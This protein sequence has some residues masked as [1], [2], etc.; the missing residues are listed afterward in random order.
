M[1]AVAIKWRVR[2]IV[3]S[4]LLLL[5]A[6]YFVIISSNL[7]LNLPLE[8]LLC[9]TAEITEPCVFC[10]FASIDSKQNTLN[11]C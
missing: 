1:I 6:I 4:L 8:D 11:Q 10:S 5:F 9:I 2:G 7:V 3:L